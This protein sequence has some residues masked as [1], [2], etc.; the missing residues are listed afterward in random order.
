MHCTRCNHSWCWSCGENP[1]GWI[2]KT[3][4]GMMICAVMGG[5]KNIFTFIIKFLL[6]LVGIPILCVIVLI[7]SGISLP[8]L[9]IHENLKYKYAGSV[10][11]KVFAI[12]GYVLLSVLL[13]PLVLALTAVIIAIT[14]V[15]IFILYF[16]QTFKIFRYWINKKR[17]MEADL[18]RE[19]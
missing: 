13:L 17:Q 14:I 1:E 6:G 12:V 9:G 16:Y 8:I 7:I 10:K 11:K 15:P 5:S 4:V 2:H 19:I 3:I 18:E